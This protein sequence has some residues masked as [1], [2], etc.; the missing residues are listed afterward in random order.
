MIAKSIRLKVAV[1]VA[2]LSAAMTFL[3]AAISIGWYMQEE[4]QDMESNHL[5]SNAEELHTEES[6]IVNLAEAWGVA[7][8][9]VICVTAAGAWML[10]GAMARP[11][12]E[13]A[14][15]AE[16]IDARTLH[17]RLGVPKGQDEISRLVTVLNSLLSRLEKSFH[18]SGRFAADAS[19]E[20][21]TPLAIM[22]GEIETA[23]QEDPLAPQAVVLANLLG[24]IQHLSTIAEKLLLLARAD[25]GRLTVDQESLD[26]G[27]IVK[28]VAEDFR[29]MAEESNIS[30]QCEVPPGICARGDAMLLRQ[31]A[32]NLFDN[33]LKYNVPG[34][35]I[36]VRLQ[37]PGDN[38]RLTISNSGPPIPEAS[39]HRLFERFFRAEFA[40]DRESGGTGLGL[41]LCSE[42][43]GAH[44]GELRLL[45]SGS[46]GTTFLFEFPGSASRSLDKKTAH[47]MSSADTSD[48]IA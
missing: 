4:K 8:P 43:A 13:L 19:H 9:V 24:E 2:L 37:T 17:A 14:D 27:A 25:A 5:E 22:R 42:I 47:A 26:F 34:G 44:G 18:Q 10:S 30:V 36:R 39:Q 16:K 11:L 29:L 48:E 32:L 23:I 46:N 21:R 15:A 6:N 20:L 40:R 38:V 45:E 7:F 31:A 1:A 3:S 41:S 28:D 35:W 33:A 12:M